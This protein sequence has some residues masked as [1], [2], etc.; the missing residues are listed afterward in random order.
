M[1]L[2]Y[3]PTDNKFNY[4]FTFRFV[5]NIF[6]TQLIRKKNQAQTHTEHFGTGVYVTDLIFLFYLK[7]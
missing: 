2:L 3:S 7:R 5:E 6:L 4:F 1:D